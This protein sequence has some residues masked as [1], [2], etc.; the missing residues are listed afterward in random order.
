MFIF[1]NRKVE[2]FTPQILTEP[3]NYTLNL[4]SSVRICGVKNSVNS[5]YEKTTGAGP[6]KILFLNRQP[7]RASNATT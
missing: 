5:C 4:W 3:T 6:A 2:K 1:S 7:K